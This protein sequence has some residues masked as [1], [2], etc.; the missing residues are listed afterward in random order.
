MHEARPAIAHPTDEVPTAAARLTITLL[1]DSA[2][3][4]RQKRHLIAIWS[5]VLGRRKDKTASVQARPIARKRS[6]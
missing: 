4:T 6:S 1:P 2:V 3:S 5:A